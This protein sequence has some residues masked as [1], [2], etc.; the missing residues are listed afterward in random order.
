M[1][2]RMVGLDDL[3]G[4]WKVLPDEHVNVKFSNLC[5]ARDSATR[6]IRRQAI[7]IFFRLSSSAL[8]FLPA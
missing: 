4:K 8:L 1:I 6:G 5:H 3:I 7:K 2:G